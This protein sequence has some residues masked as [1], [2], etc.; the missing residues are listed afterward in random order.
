MALGLRRVSW[1]RIVVGPDGPRCDVVG[2]GHRRTHIR[3]VPLHTATALMAAG[4]PGVVRRVGDP[5]DDA[6]KRPMKV[7]G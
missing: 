7:R 6:S 1:V 5:I 3:R 4:V 2:T